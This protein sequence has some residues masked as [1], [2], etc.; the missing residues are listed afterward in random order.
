MCYEQAET[1]LGGGFTRLNG[2]FGCEPSQIK[3]KKKQ[4]ILTSKSLR[5]ST[6]IHQTQ[7]LITDEGPLGKNVPI[8]SPTL[9]QDCLQP[10]C[11]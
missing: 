1:E 9:L 2:G 3:I 6:N 10:K 7:C 8:I 5:L 4:G 11:I